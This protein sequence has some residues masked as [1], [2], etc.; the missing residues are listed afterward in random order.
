M[1]QPNSGKMS[2]SQFLNDDIFLVELFPKEYGVIAF[3]TVIRVVLALRLTLV[4]IIVFFV[5]NSVPN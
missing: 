5:H 1:N 3:R 2:P 4:L